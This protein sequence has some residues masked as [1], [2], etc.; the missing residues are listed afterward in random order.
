MIKINLLPV[1]AERRKEFIRK[2]LS[3]L[4][5]SL[6]CA[7]MVMGFLFFHLQNRYDD[8]KKSLARTNKEIKQLQPIIKK[9]DTYKKQKQDIS[10]KIA[11]IIDLDRYRL[12]PV[13]VLSDLNQFRPEKLWFTDIREKGKHLTLGGVAVD[14]ETVVTF[15]NRLK[16]SVPL[17][18]SDLTL[19]RARK[20]KDVELKAF[21]IDCPLDL[22]SLPEMLKELEE[23]SPAK[24]SGEEQNG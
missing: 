16:K 19:L 14:N 11:I 12:A 24:L 5:L 18:N 2:Q 17:K 20:V 21:T 1:R 10:R 3:I 8:T 22:D 6:V 4:V 15:L 23:A 9:I 7:I 13:V